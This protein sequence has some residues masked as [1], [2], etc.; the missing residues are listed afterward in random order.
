M[1]KVLWV[2]YLR[3]HLQVN[4]QNTHQKK[5]LKLPYFHCYNKKNLRNLKGTDFNLLGKECIVW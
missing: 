1:I 2:E 3:L 4:N 5:N